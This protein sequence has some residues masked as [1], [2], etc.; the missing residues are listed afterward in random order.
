MA[1]TTKSNHDS[2]ERPA[3]DFSSELFPAAPAG[4]APP[5]PPPTAPQPLWGTPQA[6]M[7]PS[8]AS[9]PSTAHATAATGT[10][11]LLAPPPPPTGPH[12]AQW[13]Q[14]TKPIEGSFGDAYFKKATPRTPFEDEFATGSATTPNKAKFLKFAVLAA[15]A[16]GAFFVT[17]TF[18]F[19][20]EPHLYT[21]ADGEITEMK[22]KKFFRPLEGYRYQEV[23]QVFLD[24]A[25]S[26]VAADPN[27]AKAMNGLTARGV[28]QGGQVVAGAV[29]ISVGPEFMAD[30]AERRSGLDELEKATDASV[31][32]LEVDGKVA[33]VSSGGAWTGSLTYYEN[34]MVMVASPT[35]ATTQDVT[36]ELLQAQ[37]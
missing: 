9:T 27:A 24:Q 4:A 37:P 23:P 3:D 33:Y 8:P 30:R 21:G 6:M 1:D 19:N 5:P 20:G 10:Q 14:P 29:V 11:V 28:M 35:E 15:V 34:L 18:F 2:T 12:V 7:A 16:V 13:S 17:S 36:T 25:R 32:K 31:E 22:P 26:I